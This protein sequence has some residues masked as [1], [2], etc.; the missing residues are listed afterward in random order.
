MKMENQKFLKILKSKPILLKKE[1]GL[2][3]KSL[4]KNKKLIEKHKKSL[5]KK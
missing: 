2:I 5:I 1:S 4:L 3:I